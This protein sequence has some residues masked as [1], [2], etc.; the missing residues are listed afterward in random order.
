MKKLGKRIQE[1]MER[2]R[3]ERKKQEIIEETGKNGKNRERIDS[4]RKE[5]KETVKNG[6]K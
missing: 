5:W 2:D 1:G 3:I 4:N 6:K